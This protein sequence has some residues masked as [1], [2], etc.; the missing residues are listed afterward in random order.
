MLL[1]LFIIKLKCFKNILQKVS[2]KLINNISINY[3]KI[4]IKLV[5][6]KLEKYSSKINYETV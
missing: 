4:Y 5:I 2:M 3:K 1:I 6:R